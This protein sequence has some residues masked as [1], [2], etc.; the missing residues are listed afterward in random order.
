MCASVYVYMCTHVCK[1]V[2]TCMCE[3]LCTHLCASVCVAIIEEMRIDTILHESCFCRP[4][5]LVYGL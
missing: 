3:C 2:H 4:K 5:L 1:C